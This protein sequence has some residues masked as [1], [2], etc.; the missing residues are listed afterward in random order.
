[1][2]GRA[3]LTG[4]RRGL[5]VHVVVFVALHHGLFK[6]TVGLFVS[7]GIARHVP[8]KRLM[9][10]VQM[11]EILGTLGDVLTLGVNRRFLNVTLLV[12]VN[13]EMPV[14]SGVVLE[15]ASRVF[16]IWGEIALRIGSARLGRVRRLFVR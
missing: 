11:L 16:N 1:V 2:N 15:L 14:L 3:D 9:F 13:G 8:R 4:K 5:A 7:K 10:W 6:I 12:V